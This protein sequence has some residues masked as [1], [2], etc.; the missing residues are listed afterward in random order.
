MDNLIVIWLALCW[1]TLTAGIAWG[2]E[3]L[4]Q[5]LKAR[6]KPLDG[7]NRNRGTNKIVQDQYTT[8]KGEKAR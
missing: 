5:H 6:K 1:L 4:E 3:R 8:E 2:L 7:G